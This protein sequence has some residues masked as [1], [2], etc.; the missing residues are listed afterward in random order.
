MQARELE[1]SRSADRRLGLTPPVYRCCVFW[2]DARRSEPDWR[3]EG[4]YP[5]RSLTDER[6]RGR[7]T[8]D[9]KDRNATTPVTDLVH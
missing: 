9:Q 6:S 5:L 8:A 3:L 4:E 2:L 7:G 1:A